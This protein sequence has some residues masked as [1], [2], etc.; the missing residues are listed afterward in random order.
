[1]TK[2]LKNIHNIL[3]NIPTDLSTIELI[4]NC[5]QVCMINDNRTMTINNK[6]N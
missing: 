3:K 6:T 1:M 4:N 5:I 2:Y